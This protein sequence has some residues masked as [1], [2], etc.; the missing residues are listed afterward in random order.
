MPADRLFGHFS[1]V[2]IPLPFFDQV[3][4]NPL[5]RPGFMAEAQ[6]GSRRRQ[7]PAFRPQVLGALLVLI[8]K[9]DVRLADVMERQQIENPG[10]WQRRNRAETRQQG[11]SDS[12]HIQQMTPEGMIGL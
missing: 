4:S 7:V 12:G 11:L 9:L 5:C 10:V 6:I 8:L 2:S 3:S 1:S